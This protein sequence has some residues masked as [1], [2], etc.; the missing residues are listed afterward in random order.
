VAPFPSPV[1]VTI[2][3]RTFAA[4]SS[5]LKER[6]QSLGKS[7]SVTCAGTTTSAEAANG[8]ANPAP[9]TIAAAPAFLKKS[10]RPVD[11]WFYID[12]FEI[13]HLISVYHEHL[14]NMII[15]SK[16]L[17]LTYINGHL[18]RWGESRGC[19]KSSS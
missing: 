19:Y 16:K 3:S 10:L 9:V 14:E 6:P 18:Q 4:S 11:G 13:V 1:A 12:K 17:C 5:Y 15:F 2:C 7:Y 8:A